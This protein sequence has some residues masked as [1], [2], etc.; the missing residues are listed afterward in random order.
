MVLCFSPKNMI[1]IRS[2]ILNGS[3]SLNCLELKLDFCSHVVFCFFNPPASDS[4]CKLWNFGL[5]QYHFL[6]TNHIRK[7]NTVITF[8]T[9]DLYSNVSWKSFLDRVWVY[10]DLILKRVDLWGHNYA[11]IGTWNQG[12][13]CPKIHQTIPLDELGAFWY[14]VSSLLRCPALSCCG[15][16]VLWEDWDLVLQKNSQKNPINDSL[17]LQKNSTFIE[18]FMTKKGGKFQFNSLNYN[19]WALYVSNIS[20]LHLPTKHVTGQGT[21]YIYTHQTS[22]GGHSS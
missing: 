2:V 4:D 22:L 19:N 17:C 6:C 7:Y 5:T 12:I 10:M 8:W 9:I 13:S 3:V 15:L 11:N 1:Q 16:S 21:S 20:T 14:P 18:H